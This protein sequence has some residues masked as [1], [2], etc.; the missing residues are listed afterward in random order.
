MATRTSLALL[1]ATAALIPA[2]AL[3]V[4]EGFSDDVDALVAAS[5]DAT[6][7]GI[8][9]VVTED[10]EVVYTGA[11]GMADL[12][13]ARPIE[14]DTLF[15]LGSITKQFASAVVLQLAQEGKLS[16]DD[17]LSKF[18]PDYPAS[19]ATV[20]VRQL[21]N[22]T[23]GIASYTSMPGFMN[24]TNLV[25]KWK[26]RDLIA[27]F[28]DQPT[29]FA[30]GDRQLYNNS[31][32]IL[33]GAVIEAVT[34]KPW[35]QAVAERI[36]APLGLSTIA[37][38]ADEAA[39]PDMAL[40]YTRSEAGGAELASPI[41]ATVPAAA[42]ALRG[43]VL[44]LAT[45]ANALHGGE[46]IG[47]DL[48]RQMIAPT[49]LNDGTVVNYGLGVD[50]EKFR[51]RHKIGHGG[52]ING[53][54][55]ASLYLPEEGIFVAVFNNHDSP[56]ISSAT[57]MARIAA[58]AIG[59]PFAAMSAVPLDMA[60][61]APLL[62]EYRIDPDQSRKFYARDGKLFTMRTGGR[63]LEVF[64]A[65]G[66]KF[67]YGPSSLTWFGIT[68][69][70]DGTAEMAMYQDGA[71][72]AEMSRW[73][74]EI[75]AAPDVAIAADVLQ[76]YAGTYTGPIGT[77]TLSVDDSGTLLAKLNEQPALPL[78]PHSATRFMVSGIDAAVEIKHEGARVIGAEISQ[79]G[80]SIPFTRNA[81]AD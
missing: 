6:G 76:S 46:V 45:W 49:V 77:L 57:L 33:V 55:T 21:L 2:Q 23:S 54:N 39:L 32:Y 30:P 70:E 69:A 1:L 37:S 16:L 13:Q 36:S 71:S 10:G 40:G 4:P 8:S 65:G 18:V 27:A 20:T 24:D 51:G 43:T 29:D 52:G 47:D 3:A 68:R 75:T 67:F 11:R 58:M 48:Y 14:P 50:V 61:V 22:H 7:P 35:D 26:T 31:G 17:P 19:G 56:E 72:E 28:Q 74:G 41:N 59:E 81:D 5:V 80:Q 64:S 34:G 63:E 78:V 38:F 53:F 15:R 42:G 66:G 25:R 62:G 79:G 44:D 60:A 73:V 9:V 12:A